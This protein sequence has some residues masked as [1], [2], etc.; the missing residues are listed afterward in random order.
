MEAISTKSCL[1]VLKYLPRLHSHFLATL[2]RCEWKSGQKQKRNKEN[3]NRKICPGQDC[4]AE[5]KCGVVISPFVLHAALVVAAVCLRWFLGQ[6]RTWYILYIRGSFGLFL[7]T[8][9]MKDKKRHVSMTWCIMILRGPS[10]KLQDRQQTIN[11]NK[12][13]SRLLGQVSRPPQKH[14]PLWQGWPST[15][16]PP[17]SAP[18]STSSSLTLSQSRRCTA[19]SPD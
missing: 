8:N 16:S 12:L 14:K 17:P 1:C 3:E 9:F 11:V 18:A 7:Q 5:G 2:V 13:F 19:R 15:C 10:N 4:L 6:N